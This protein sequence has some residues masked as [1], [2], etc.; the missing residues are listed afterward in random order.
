M[1]NYEIRLASMGD[2]KEILSIWK[3]KE[4]K[5]YLSIPFNNEIDK[6]ILGQRMY[7]VVLDNDIIGF[8]AYQIMKRIPEIRIKHLCVDKNYRRNRI[9][10]KIITRIC[11]DLVDVN[12]PITATCRDG[13]ENNKFYDRYKLKDYE[14]THTKTLLCRKYTL[15][16]NKIIKEGIFI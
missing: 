3:S 13:A 5:E 2:K 15:D 7:C 4:N 11:F 16:K 9:T 6:C 1:N 14:I 10:T 8:G 12:L